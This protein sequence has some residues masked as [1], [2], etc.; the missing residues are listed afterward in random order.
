MK[1]AQ[2]TMLYARTQEADP[3]RILSLF[4]AGAIA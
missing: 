2:N 4:R 1:T 3:R